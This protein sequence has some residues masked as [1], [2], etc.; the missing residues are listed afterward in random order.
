MVVRRGSTAGSVAAGDAAE[1]RGRILTEATRS[2]VATGYHGLSMRELAESAGVSKA[3]LYYHF[4][5]KETLFLAVLDTALGRVEALLLAPVPDSARVPGGEA[6]A[7]LHAFV[8]GLLEW[9]PEER[10]VIRLA[11]QEIGHV[12]PRARQA[13]ERDYRRRFVGRIE[14]ILRD[15]IAAGELRPLDPAATTWLLLGLLYPL[16]AVGYD[17]RSQPGRETAELALSLFFDGAAA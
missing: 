6:R 2:F 14:A 12:S 1:T 7:R 10:A 16:T 3:L 15:A 4:R 8:A 11:S 17:G 13:F 5:D 9:P